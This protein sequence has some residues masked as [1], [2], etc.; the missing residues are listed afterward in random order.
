MNKL[1]MMLWDDAVYYNNENVNVFSREEIV[2]I[3]EEEWGVDE[4]VFDI[5]GELSVKDGVNLL[6]EVGE[7]GERRE[8][9]NVVDDV[10]SV[11]IVEV[12]M[13]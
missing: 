6:I 9:L 5:E 13:K 2:K 7:E 8:V 1:F 3:F 10:V 12:C 11:S 4:L